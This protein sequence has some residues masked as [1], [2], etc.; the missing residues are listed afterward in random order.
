V[1]P[2]RVEGGGPEPRRRVQEN[3]GEER[4][5][6]P[7][8]QEALFRLEGDRE[9]GDE[10]LR[11]ER[12]EEGRREDGEEEPRQRGREEAL[13]GLLPL[14]LAGRDEPRDE[15]REKGRS[16]PSPRRTREPRKR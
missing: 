9:E 10:R 7:L 13:R 1:P 12:E 8:G 2:L 3:E 4:E 16:A 5:E 11:R 6:E 14:P 15:R